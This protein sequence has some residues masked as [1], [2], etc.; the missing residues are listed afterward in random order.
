MGKALTFILGLVFGAIVGGLL[1]FYSFVGAPQA[2]EKPGELIKAPESGGSPSGTAQIVLKQEFFN[3]VLQT[4]FK[5]MNPP[6]YPLKIA[7]SNANED[8]RSAKFALQN[9]SCEGEIKLLEK[10]SD[11]QTAVLFEDKKIDAQ[12]GFTGNV[13]IFGNCVEFNGWSRANLEL[14]F[15]KEK[16]K[17][18]G[19]IN[20]DTVNLDGVSP[21][22]TAAVTPLIQNALNQN[23]NPI[24][25]LNGK[26]ISVNL[27]IDATGGNLLANINDVRAEVKDK[28][29]NLFV[30]Y[31]FE[32]VS[33]K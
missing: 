27:K 9:N 4:I 29:L 25:I 18:F 12:L 19:V 1:T 21:I 16:Q 20:V 2:I 32:G 11:V 17:V 31:D 22:I 15:D 28:A 5:D 13:N 30:T 8:P 26:Q 23:V 10:G 3:S 7:G 6:S 14:R 24:E 33:D